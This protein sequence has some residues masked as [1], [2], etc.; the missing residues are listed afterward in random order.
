MLLSLGPG[1][2]LES[3]RSF[4]F[5][6]TLEWCGAE[7]CSGNELVEYF[8]NGVGGKGLP[9]GCRFVLTDGSVD[10]AV[11]DVK[12]CRNVLEEE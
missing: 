7:L 12:N 8:S 6:E 9:F 5:P 10:D 2:G 4:P 3:S 11:D 1:P